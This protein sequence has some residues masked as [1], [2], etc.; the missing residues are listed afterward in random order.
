M[1]ST[2]AAF[3]SAVNAQ[4]TDSAFLV[5]L[6]IYH[7]SIGPPDTLY[8]V[9]AQKNITCLGQEYTAFPFEITLPADYDDQLPQV[10]ISIDN[11]DQSIIAEL[12]GIV[13][14]PTISISVVHAPDDTLVYNDIEAGPFELSLRN[15]DYNEMTIT[16]DLQSEDLL[17]E[18]Y[19]G[20]FYTPQTTPGLWG[21]D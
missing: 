16:G 8:F 2:S 15:I 3:R 21:G 5:L 18:P 11:I 10:Q 19:P 1:R 20:Y 13:G 7:T 17:N 9:N 4:Q 12:R 6:S 14:P